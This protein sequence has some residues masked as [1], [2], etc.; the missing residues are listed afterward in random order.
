[1]YNNIQ[2]IHVIDDEPI[3]MEVDDDDEAIVATEVLV[4]KPR[5]KTISAPIRRKVWNMYIGEEVGKS[6]CMCC[7]DITITP[8]MFE[9][10]HVISD[11]DGGNA[12]VE[13]LRPICCLCNRAMGSKNMEVFMTEKFFKKSLNWYGKKV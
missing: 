11:H 6:K 13:N 1:M 9:C 7:N 12:S 3:P 10:G 8:F 2:T 5:R 4:V